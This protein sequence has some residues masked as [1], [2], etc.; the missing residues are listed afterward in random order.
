MILFFIYFFILNIIL[1]LQ[2]SKTSL[3]IV[4]HPYILIILILHH[5]IN[6]FIL[7]GCFFNNNLILLFHFI[8]II[9]TIIYWIFNKNYCDLTLF[10]NKICGWEKNVPFNDIFN[11]L[12]FKKIKKWNEF[13]HFFIIIIAGIISFSKI[14]ISI[15]KF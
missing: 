3:C 13:W 15:I 5:L 2:T 1:D 12:G 7:L 14:L 10:V 6:S 4:N 11:I 9:I 8:I